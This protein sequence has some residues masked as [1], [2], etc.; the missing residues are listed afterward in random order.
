MLFLAA[1]NGGQTPTD[2]TPPDVPSGLA[3]TAGDAQ[4]S[5]SWQANSE[6]DLKQYNLYSG[7]SSTELTLLASIPGGSES[8][9]ATG[10]TNGTTYFFALDAEDNAG[11]KSSR[12]GSV[13]ATP[14][15]DPDPDPDPDPTPPAV[16]TGNIPDG[17]TDIAINTTISIS[18]SKAMN[19]TATETAFSSSPA[20]D[21]EFSWNIFDTTLSCKPNNPLSSNTTYSITLGTGA[22]DT[23]G[24][25]LGSP[26]SFS[27]TTG[28]QTLSSCRFGESNFSSC[29]FGD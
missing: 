21:C 10:L 25:P 26:Y 27:F 17:A 6:A 19:R 11:N 3:A 18:F 9:V 5:L 13:S 7:T 22:Q 8:Y 12:S 23:A 15:A 24:N 16:T 14:Q 1:C 20:I 29:V 2:T 4:V 28:T